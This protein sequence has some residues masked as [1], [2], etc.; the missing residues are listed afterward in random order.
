MSVFELY[1][2]F[3]VI[4]GIKVVPVV[5]LICFACLAVAAIPVAIETS[6]EFFKAYLSKCL[7]SA[8]FLIPLAAVI[9]VAVPSTDQ[10]KYII[11]GSYVTNIE[12][13]EKLPPNVVDAA[14]KFLEK[15]NEE[16]NK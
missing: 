9:I 14:N 6:E 11:G 10:M 8:K 4:P 12:N 7:N 13:I 3:T 2:I 5:I 15:M 1:L 16:S